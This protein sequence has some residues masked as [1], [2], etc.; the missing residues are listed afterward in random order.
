M[1]KDFIV[2]DLETTGVDIETCRIVQIS[3]T[4]IVNGKYQDRISEYI[5]PGCH[6][7]QEATLVHGITDDRVANCPTFEELAPKI[8]DY[9]K[10]FNVAGYNIGRFDVPVLYYHLKRSGI[11]WKLDFKIVDVMRIFTVEEPRTLAGAVKFY[12]GE[13]MKDAHDASVDVDYT[14]KVL[15]KQLSKYK[16][17]IDNMEKYNGDMVDWAGKL[18]KNDNG[19][20]IIN[21]GKH[22]GSLLKEVPRDYKIWMLRERILGPDVENMVRDNYL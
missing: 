9:I 14:I 20:I 7:P 12:L 1:S 21:F 18:A 19:E 10:G 11:D 17:D 16:I 8:F 4:K 5:N 2:F 6:I 13:E 22:K 3:A 15:N